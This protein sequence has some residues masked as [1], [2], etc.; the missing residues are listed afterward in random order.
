VSTTHSVEPSG[1]S[2]ASSGP[3]AIASIVVL[4]SRVSEPFAAIE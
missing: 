1:E 3:R 4:P 2:R